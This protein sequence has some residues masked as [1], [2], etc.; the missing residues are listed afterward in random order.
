MASRRTRNTAPQEIRAP[1]QQPA[2]NQI[3]SKLPAEELAQI[4]SQAE[5]MWCALRQELFQQGEEVELVYFPLTAM[6]SLLVVLSNGTT[7]EAMTVGR[8][9]FVGLQLLNGL[10]SARYNGV[11]QIEGAFLVMKSE[12]FLSV[13]DRL[14]DLRS[15]LQRYSQYASEVLAQSAACN[16]VHTIRERLAK[17]LLITG[18]AAGSNEFRLT[19]EFLSQMLAVRR[20]GVTEALNDLV[21]KGLLSKSYGQIR[22]VDVDGLKSAA[23]EC[24]ETISSKAREL[25]A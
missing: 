5:E 2:Q 20:A 7:I 15:R 19:Q 11:C 18:D 24:Y 4:T 22:L 23:C 13:I 25:L 6:A 3:L 1:A 9:G 14:P 21:E 17:W 8:E 10:T 12:A 16:S